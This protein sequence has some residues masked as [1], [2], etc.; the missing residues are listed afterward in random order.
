MKIL[1]A[2]D[3]SCFSDPALDLVK[4]FVGPDPYIEFKVLTAYEAPDQMAVAPFAPI[5]VYSQEFYEGL[6]IRAEEIATSAELELTKRFPRAHV[7]TCV[8][9]DEPGSAI[10]SKSLTWQPDLII[11]GSH[12]HGAIGRVLLGSVSDYVVHHAPCSV[13]V[14]R[15]PKHSKEKEQAYSYSSEPSKFKELG[16]S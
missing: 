15:I 13:V 9:M 8:V 16:L 1:I 10:V 2:I 4:D 6:R 12:G 5:P 11:V 14:A 3:G 7:S